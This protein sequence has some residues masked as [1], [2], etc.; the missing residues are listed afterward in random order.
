M[1][2]QELDADLARGGFERPHQAVA[3]RC[4]RAVQRID[5]A[6]RLHLRPIEHGN[7]HLA[8]HRIAVRAA[9]A[10][11]GN[12]LHE[13]HAVLD[14][15]LEGLGA[16]VGEGADDFLVVVTIVRRA[17]GLNHRPVGQIPK[18]EVGRVIDAGLLLER[19]AAAKRNVCA[20]AD[21]MTADIAIGIDDDDRGTRLL[22][23][24]RG[25]DACRARADDHNVGFTVP[26]RRRLRCLRGGRG[27]RDEAAGCDRGAGK[28]C[29]PDQIAACDVALG[30][31]A[32]L[33][34]ILWPRALS[35]GLTQKLQTRPLGKLRPEAKR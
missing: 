30:L 18:H 16:I 11:V 14:Q 13:L 4:G 1:L 29:V 32:L 7:M 33:L 22:G 23:H 3:V 31:H 27:R 5:L 21:C 17:V 12:V 10:A 24:D 34:K 28:T 25:R 9:G 6:S 8:R 20:A 15:E 2:E 35:N 26:A 19:R